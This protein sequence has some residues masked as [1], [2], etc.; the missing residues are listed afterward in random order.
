MPLSFSSSSFLSSF[1][2]W[3]IFCYSN[4]FFLSPVFVWIVWAVVVCYFSILF[5]LL[6]SLY[7]SFMF[8]FPIPFPPVSL[9][10][11]FPSSVLSFFIT[12]PHL[13]VL[14]HSVSCDFFF[15]F[16]CCFLRP[17]G[18]LSSRLCLLLFVAI[19]P[20]PPTAVCSPPL[21]GRGRSGCRS[22]RLSGCRCLVRP[23]FHSA[24]DEMVEWIG[25][26]NMLVASRM[27][28]KLAEREMIR[29][30]VMPRMKASRPGRTTFDH[31]GH[32]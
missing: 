21:F 18:R 8:G 16:S 14:H 1:S 26:Q 12:L 19:W 29:K 11:P 27:A 4:F 24:N 15:C 6:S 3:I 30:A 9:P 5:L 22:C 23:S 25:Y 7:S 32:F 31:F 20:C 17:F 28:A 13:L 2:S 10:F